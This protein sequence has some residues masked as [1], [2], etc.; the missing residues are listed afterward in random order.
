LSSSEQTYPARPPG[1]QPIGGSARRIDSFGKVT[2]QT[3]YAEDIVMPGMGYAAVLRSPHHHA[4]LLALDTRCAAELPGVRRVL[5]AADIPGE[6]N[7]TGYSHVEPLLTPLGD[8][9]RQKGAPV[10]LVVAD[11]IDLARQALGLIE[12]RYEVLPH[13]F[14]VEAALQPGAQQLYPAGN[15]LNTFTLAHGDLQAAWD[16]SDTLIETEYETAFQEHSTLERETTLGYIDEQGRVTV[17][18]GTH[19]PHWQQN[20]IGQTIG[21]PASQVRVIVPPTGGSFGAR[22]DPWPLVA[23][24]LMTHLL[25]CPV[26]LAY[27]RSEV[28]EATPK[29]HPYQ[30]RMKIGAQADGSLTGIHVR[31]NANTGGYDSAGYWIPNYA[32]TASGGPYRWQ[33]VD[34]FAQAVYTNAAKSGQF[35]GFGTPQSVFGLECSLDELVQKLALDPLDF[36]RRNSLVEGVNSFLGYPVG[37]SFGFLEVLDAIEPRYRQLVAEAEAFNAAGQGNLQR[38][39]IGLAGMW[40]RFGKSGTL[41]VETH[42]ELAP[43]GHFILYCSA[44]DYGQGISTVMVQLAA[45]TLGVLPGQ[46]EL[47]NA[48]TGLTPDSGIQGASRATYFIG[49]S[50]VQAAENLRKNLFGVA[51][52]MLDCDPLEFSLQGERIVARSDASRSVSLVEVAAEFEALGKSR[53]VVGMLDLTAQFPDGIRPDYIP[54]FV[55]GAQVAQVLVDMQSGLVTVQRIIAAHDVGRAINPSDAAGQVQGAVLMGVGT[56]L[57]EEY[58][59]GI[60]S[61]FTNYVLPMIDAMP[62]TEVILVETPSRYGPYGAKGLGEAALLPTAPAIVNGLS[63]A[64][65]VRIRR[66]PATPPRLLQA[67]GHT[68]TS[69]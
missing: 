10:A 69:E 50:V 52:E 64:I 29:R 47:V 25:R 6:N 48:D 2:G 53:R 61:G 28:F 45:E 54:I 68:N 46:I 38:M 33:A 21:L 3:R 11:S 14:D 22:Q 17:I 42:A 30:I 27:S 63:R 49:G 26:R 59:P 7:L 32:V 19:E 5:S 65:G 62:Q 57:S 34:A 24:G 18:G 40:Y 13:N 1:S 67:L 43:D 15:V 4:R 23:A 55:T 36:R 31:I 39:G 9:V 58:I 44:P 51:A 56:A 60:S 8:T 41:R 12:A 20:F 16:S 66:L 35:R 37:E